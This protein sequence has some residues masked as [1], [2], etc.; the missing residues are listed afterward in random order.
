MHKSRVFLFALLSFAAGVGLRSFF[1]IGIYVVGVFAAVGG[2]LLFF[3]LWERERKLFG[4]IGLLFVA[5]T[6]GIMRFSWHTAAQEDATILYYANEA[7]IS[8]RG[9]V[10]D[11][12]DIRE[13]NTRL[14]VEVVE[15]LKEVGLPHM[16]DSIKTAEL[17]PYGGSPT[18]AVSIARD[19]RGRVLI[20]TNRYPA[21]SYGDEIIVAGEIQKPEPFQDVD[22]PAYLA[23]DQIYAVM[24]Y[25]DMEFVSSGKGDILHSTLFRIKHAFERQLERIV[26]EPHAAFLKGIILGSRASMPVW[27]LE[28]FRITGV[29][30]IIAL[31]GFNITIIA[32][33]LSRVLRRCTLGPQ[34]SFWISLVAI[35]LFTIMT[36]ASPSIVRAALMGALVLLARKEGRIYI[37]ANALVFAG[38]VMVLHNPAVLRF[39]VAFQLSFFATAGLLFLSPHL[40][41]HLRFVPKGMGFRGNLA[42][43]LSAQAAVLPLI[44]FYFGTFS[45]VS[46]PANLLILT[47]IPYAMFFGFLSVLAG[48]ASTAVGIGIGSVA[49]ILSFYIISVSTFFSRVPR[50]AWEMGRIPLWTALTIAVGVWGGIIGLLWK[51]K[52]KRYSL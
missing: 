15:V 40:E 37:G 23:K 28:A 34:W 13:K 41:R 8:V 5:F 31:S 11:E 14:V 49:H 3:F 51:R 50:A 29:I 10:V 33:N 32:D 27:L 45:F 35:I 36:G 6:F 22:Y 38:T 2:F 1:D 26:P 20:F 17:F 46:I 52:G 30:H 47:A 18:S 9:V 16:E 25:P 21:F 12:L 44:L 24:Y 4:L 48:F 39:D 42:S 19:V 43:T 7:R